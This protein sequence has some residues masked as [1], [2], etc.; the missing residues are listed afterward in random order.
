MSSTPDYDVLIVGAGF[1][2]VGAAIKLDR[3]GVTNFVLIEA[4]DGVG[5]WC[6]DR[7]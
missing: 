2:G 1:S 4:V 7:A 6:L 5:G 3:G